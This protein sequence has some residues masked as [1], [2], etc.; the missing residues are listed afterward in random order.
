MTV[1][2]RMVY[3]R[4]ENETYVRDSLLKRQF[5][6][7]FSSITYSRSSLEFRIEKS[8]F[9]RTT[10]ETEITMVGLINLYFLFSLF[11]F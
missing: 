1:E 8:S 10:R 3:S 4:L 9:S 5:R 7:V 6:R 2:Q 11:F